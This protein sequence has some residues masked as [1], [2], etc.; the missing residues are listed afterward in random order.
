MNRWDRE[1]RE[2][3]GGQ[4]RNGRSLNV[5]WLVAED[6]RLARAVAVAL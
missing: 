3:E 6:G 4:H 5:V 1:L 2:T